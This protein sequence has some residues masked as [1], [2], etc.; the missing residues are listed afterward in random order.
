VTNQSNIGATD[1]SLEDCLC[2]R[3]WQVFGVWYKFS[4]ASPTTVEVST[5][6]QANFDTAIYVYS[7]GCGS[8]VCEAAEDDTGGC[9][10]GTSCAIVS[11]QPP[12]IYVLV[13][14]YWGGT[15]IFDLT[16]STTALLPNVSDG[17]DGKD[18]WKDELFLFLF[19]FEPSL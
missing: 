13:I 4:V 6:N 14:G 10:G 8:L 12:D 17:G 18:G 7:G 19:S 3:L 9:G 5:C 16:V 1:D 15:G 11:V 2:L